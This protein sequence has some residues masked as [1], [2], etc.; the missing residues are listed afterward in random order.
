MKENED[1]TTLASP[2]ANGI[3]KRE[4]VKGRC[5]GPDTFSEGA[6]MKLRDVL[7]LSPAPQREESPTEVKPLRPVVVPRE[8]VPFFDDAQE[9][10][11]LLTTE[12]PTA[13]T[14]PFLPRPLG[15]EDALDP[16]TVWT[17]LFDWLIE[18]HPDHFHAICDA[19][20]ALNRMEGQGITEGE[21]Y[22]HAC[23][24]LLTLPI[25]LLL[26]L[27]WNEPIN[28]LLRKNSEMPVN[29]Y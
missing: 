4:G 8:P 19:E 14:R 10:L 27:P 2:A 12:P 29:L 18:H 15:Q 25:G 13:K 16:W 26:W 21:A 5:H 9:L 22:Q 28:S 1:V 20:D 6:S 3:Q 7:G 23:R 24:E 11:R 17:P